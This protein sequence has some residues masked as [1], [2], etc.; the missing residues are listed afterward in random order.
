MSADEIKQASPERLAQIERLGM[1][2]ADYLQSLPVG[3][4]MEVLLY[5]MVR[6]FLDINPA[7]GLTQLT[8]FDEYAKAARITIDKNLTAYR[9]SLS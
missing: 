3:I 4:A 1:P 2:I 5:V 7:E 6:I 8:A 9:E